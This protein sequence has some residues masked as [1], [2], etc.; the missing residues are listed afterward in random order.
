MLIISFFIY[1]MTGETMWCSCKSAMAWC[2][3]RTPTLLFFIEQKW[4]NKQNTISGVRWVASRE[5]FSRCKALSSMAD[6]H[7]FGCPIYVL[8]D[9][10]QRGARVNKWTSRAGSA[11]YLGHSCE[12]AQ[13]VSLALSISTGL[14]SQQF[15]VRVKVKLANWNWI[16]IWVATT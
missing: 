2:C 7:P 9:K 12:H 15:H 3:G 14:V 1:I 13:T 11:V 8:D 5:V 16:R 10:L 4:R 6:D